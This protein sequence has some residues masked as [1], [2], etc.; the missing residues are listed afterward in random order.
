MA[1]PFD[2]QV[3]GMIQPEIIPE[4]IT[5]CK[6]AAEHATTMNIIINN[7][8]TGNAPLLARVVLKQYKGN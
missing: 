7:R 6:L 3:D 8:V 1:Y 5:L 2:K 4:A